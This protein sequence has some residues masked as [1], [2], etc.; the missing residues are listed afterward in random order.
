MSVRP[1]MTHFNIDDSAD[2]QDEVVGNVLR[3]VRPL[4]IPLATKQ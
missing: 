3:Y 2:L 4:K 1:G